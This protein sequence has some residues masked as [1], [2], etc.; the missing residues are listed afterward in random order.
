MPPIG[1][2]KG[3]P[4]PWRASLAKDGTW[5]VIRTTWLGYATRVEVLAEKCVFA[6][7]D[8]LATKENAKAR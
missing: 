6:W 2:E 4:T 7:A 3:A 8:S 1:Q 5:R